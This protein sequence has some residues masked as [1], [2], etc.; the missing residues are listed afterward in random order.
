VEKALEINVVG[1]VTSVKL[2][3]AAGGKVKVEVLLRIWVSDV[4][5]DLS[6]RGCFLSGH[7]H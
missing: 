5:F 3:D 4:V 7:I 2:G 6:L 1:S